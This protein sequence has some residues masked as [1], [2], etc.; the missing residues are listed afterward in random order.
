MT[1][2]AFRNPSC[3]QRLRLQKPKLSNCTDLPQGSPEAAWPRLKSCRAPLGFLG[4]WAVILEAW[5]NPA[6]S[7][8]CKPVVLSDFGFAWKME[9]P[10]LTSVVVT[11]MAP[12]GYG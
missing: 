1:T 8:I 11:I 4:L 5:G 9:T 10:L 3:Q 12:E 7:A 6:T 2:L